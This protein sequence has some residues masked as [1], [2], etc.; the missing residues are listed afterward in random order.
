MTGFVAPT[1]ERFR[2]ATAELRELSAPYAKERLIFQPPI[3]SAERVSRLE[4]ACQTVFEGLDAVLR[5]VCDGDVLRMAGL[6]R[7]T[8]PELRFLTRQPHQNWSTVARPDVISSGGRTVVIEINGDSPAGLF[9]L[10]DIIT[11]AQTAFLPPSASLARPAV[12]MHGLLSGLTKSFGEFDGMVAICYWRHEQ[13]VG[14]VDWQYELF[15]RELR[16]HGIPSVHCALEDLELSDDGVRHEGREVSVIYRY[17]ESPEPGAADEFAVL[18]T[19]FR[20]AESGRVGLFTGYRAEVLA[21]KAALAVLSAAT[22]IAPSLRARLAEHVPWTRIIEPRRTIYD[23]REV[24]L[25]PWAEREKDR[26]IVKPVRGHAGKGVTVGREVSPEAWAEVLATGVRG[27]A[28]DHPYIVQ[29][30]FEP[31]PL[32]V[33]FTD[34][35]ADVTSTV[36]PSVNGV[37]IVEN[38]AVAVLRRYAVNNTGTININPF[39]G[40][41]PSPVWIA[42]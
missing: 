26:L 36:T 33:A 41:A 24:D 38:T 25:L 29:E 20:I 40:Y 7:A 14:P 22:G 10:H 1:V 32:P 12:A 8:P 19:L 4:Q 21:S 11:R 15:A 37:F 31:D 17:F 13:A 2:D 6:C 42:S 34:E 27:G 39:S 30:L 35:H 9:G 28:G 3:E 18:D 23:G 5:E 16:R